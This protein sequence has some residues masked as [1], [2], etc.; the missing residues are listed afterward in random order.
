MRD[1]TFKRLTKKSTSY[2]QT[3]FMMKNTLTKAYTI[4]AVP[5]VLYGGKV[6]YIKNNYI[7]IQVL[8]ITFLLS[9]TEC[10]IK[11]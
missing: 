7:R 2:R 4:M 11:R 10:I 1:T 5:T 8:Q 3:H 6:F 9:V